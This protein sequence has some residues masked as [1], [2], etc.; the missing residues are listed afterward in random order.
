MKQSKIAICTHCNGLILA[1]HTSV[2]DREI[3][4]EF[5]VLEN[6]GFQISTE[7]VQ[8]T[9]NRKYSLYKKCINQNCKSKNL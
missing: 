4:R 7:T 2:L 9:L 5:S 1:C 8:E 3:E 6:E